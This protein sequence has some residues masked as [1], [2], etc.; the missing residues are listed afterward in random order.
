MSGTHQVDD[1]QSVQTGCTPIEQGE[2]GV[3]TFTQ[4]GRIGLIL[5]GQTRYLVLFGKFQFSF[6]QTDGFIGMAYQGFLDTWSYFG[7]QVR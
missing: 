4:A 7:N 2:G 1:M 6:C 5:L 3:I